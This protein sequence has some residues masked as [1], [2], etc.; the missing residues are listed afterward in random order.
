MSLIAAVWVDPGAESGALVYE[1]NRQ[2]TRQA[3][4]RGRMRRPRPMLFLP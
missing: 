2:A 4:D 3:L 1:N